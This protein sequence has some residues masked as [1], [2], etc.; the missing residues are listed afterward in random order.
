MRFPFFPAFAAAMLAT[1]CAPAFADPAHHGQR[2][3]PA[4]AHDVSSPAAPLHHTPLP[5]TAPPATATGDW[6]AANAAVA[7]AASDHAHHHHSAPDQAGAPKDAVSPGH[8]SHDNG[9]TGIHHHHSH[10]GQP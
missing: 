8:R 1:A 5:A 7:E 2:S 6:R 9:E 4:H 3:A 10:G